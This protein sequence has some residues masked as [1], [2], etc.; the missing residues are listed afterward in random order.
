MPGDFHDH[1]M[2]LAQTEARHAGQDHDPADA[3]R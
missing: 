1:E 2:V 3:G